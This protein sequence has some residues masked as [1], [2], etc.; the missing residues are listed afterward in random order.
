MKLG[1]K[2][3]VKST[4]TTATVISVSTQ[5]GSTILKLSADGVKL[6]NGNYSTWDES[7]V[8]LI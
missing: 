7:Q 3:K 6:W 1:R 4:G 5:V 8:D 2:V